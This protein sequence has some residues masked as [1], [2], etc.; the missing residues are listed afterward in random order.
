MLEIHQ[1]QIK[2]MGDCRM[3]IGPIINI[4]W[5]R[6]SVTRQ[7]VVYSPKESLLCYLICRTL[8][9]R[10]RGSC[11][12]RVVLLISVQFIFLFIL[13]ASSPRRPTDNQIIHPRTI[14]NYRNKTSRRTSN[15]RACTCQHA[16]IRTRKG[17]VYETPINIL[18]DAILLQLHVYTH[19][20]RRRVGISQ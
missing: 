12:R 14:E 11:A 7:G 16:N 17:I 10:R 3:Q 18:R 15:Q 1:L 4:A 20:P 6:G 9:Y 5:G 8:W 19:C 2:E 13:G